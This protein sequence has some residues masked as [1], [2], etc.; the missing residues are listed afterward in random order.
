[1]VCSRV[2]VDMSV[3][4]NQSV[5]DQTVIG[6]RFNPLKIIIPVLLALLSVSLMSQW[7][8]NNISF[9]RYCNNPEETLNA[10]QVLLQ[11]EPVIDND[12]RRR[13]MIA[14]KILFLHPKDSNESESDYMLRLRHLMLTKCQ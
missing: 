2:T 4:G 1:M 12:Q 6:P 11:D 8:A 9:P 14:A 10:L 7:Y 3:P 13:Y 5:P